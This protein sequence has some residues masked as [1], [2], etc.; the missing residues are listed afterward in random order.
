MITAH[1]LT[2]QS[3]IWIQQFCKIRSL[4][5][6]VWP[7][8]ICRLDRCCLSPISRGRAVLVWGG[9]CR[10]RGS[11]DRL[12]GLFF[13]CR[14]LLY[15]VFL[16]LA[17][18]IAW[19]SSF[20]VLQWVGRLLPSY[21]WAVIFLYLSW[22]RSWFPHRSQLKA[23]RRLKHSTSIILISFQ[24]IVSRNRCGLSGN[25]LLNTAIALS[26]LLDVLPP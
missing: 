6:P 15:A 14:V 10:S 16:K 17:L 23:R 26:L 24:Y 13:C 7:N 9:M 5:N 4:R 11:G 2:A 8:D 19:I 25:Q 3:T 18:R 1:P 20:V 22:P 12:T 21:L